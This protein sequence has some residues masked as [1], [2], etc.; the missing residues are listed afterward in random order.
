MD[1]GREFVY[2]G[3][4][5]DILET[6]EEAHIPKYSL[7]DRTNPKIRIETDDLGDAITFVGSR[8]E[9]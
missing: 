2:P 3:V 6:S 5:Y 8:L 9:H 4:A 1:E 7:R